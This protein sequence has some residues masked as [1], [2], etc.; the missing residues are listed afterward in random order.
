MFRLRSLLYLISLLVLIALPLGAQ[1]QAIIATPPQVTLALDDLSST[2][3]L[4]LTLHDLDAYQFSQNVYTD[5]AMGCPYA[6]GTPRPEGL[7]GYTFQLTYHGVL[8][9]YR[10]AADGSIAFRCDASLQQPAPTSAATACPVD[11]AGYLPPRLQVGGLGRIGTG[12]ISN[13]LRSAPSTSAQQIGVI[14]PGETV[15]ILDG[16]SCEAG[17]QIIWWR[18]STRGITGWTA[19]GQLPG[20]YFLAP[21]NSSLPAERNL[22]TI[23]SAD[24]LVPLTTLELQGVSSISF[25]ADS[26]RMALGGLR[27]L[28]VYNL[29]PL[30]LNAQLSDPGA[31]VTAIAFSPN[32]RYLAYSTRNGQLQVY[33]TLFAVR[34]TIERPP[35][36]VINSLDF[37]RDERYLLASGS[38]DPGGASPA[39]PDAVLGWEV[40]DLPNQTQL[41]QLPAQ[42]WVRNVAFS[43]DATLFA[44]LDTGLHVVDVKDGASVLDLTLTAPPLGGLAWRPVTEG[45]AAP[46]QVAFSDGAVIRLVDVESRVEQQFVGDPGF[47]PGAITFNRDGSLLAAVNLPPDGATVAS[48]VNLFDATTGDL[49]ASTPLPPSS[50]MQFSPDGTL[51]VIGTP[52]EVILLGVDVAQLAVG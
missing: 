1:A 28:T 18:V 16:P 24:T 3:G 43:L 30:E 20:D 35:N 48:T 14:Q 37:S 41:L 45:A 23:E 34:T 6:V 22:I 51:L 49:I 46:H 11:F 26:T 42:S 38:G 10:V 29:S 31:P 5:T 27:G 12:G 33:D 47:F 2:V 9:E 36:N 44:W 40:Y 52:D 50:A 19:E 25:T 32:G 15:S 13:R 7:S 17:A 4:P 8:Y 21:I 39:S